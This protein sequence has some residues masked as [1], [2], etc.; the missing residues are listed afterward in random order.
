[1]LYPVV[2]LAAGRYA[3]LNAGAVVLGIFCLAY[4]VF[5]PPH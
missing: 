5:G 3:E 2:K 4:Y 1:M